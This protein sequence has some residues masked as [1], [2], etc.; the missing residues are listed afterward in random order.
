MGHGSATAAAAFAEVKF[1]F[2]KTLVD[3]LPSNKEAQQYASERLVPTLTT[4]L[5]ELCTVKPANP[6]EWLA[7]WLID[8]NPNKPAV[9]AYE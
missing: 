6:V 1:F 3:P 4:G 2:P 8:N 9:A 5:V 7:N